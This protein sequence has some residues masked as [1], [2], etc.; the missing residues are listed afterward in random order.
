MNGKINRQPIL[1]HI[2]LVQVLIEV[3]PRGCPHVHRYFCKLE[4]PL[5]FSKSNTQTRHGPFPILKTRVS[6]EISAQN[7]SFQGHAF[8]ML[9]LSFISTF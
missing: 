7:L 5:S 8:E 6:E 2:N 3:Y 1:L 9:N 4:I